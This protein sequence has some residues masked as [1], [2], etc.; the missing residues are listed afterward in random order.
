MNCESKL[1][2]VF[3]KCIPRGSSFLKLFSSIVRPL[4]L[5]IEFLKYLLTCPNNK[6][7]F[8]VTNQILTRPHLFIFKGKEMEMQA[9]EGQPS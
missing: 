9:C 7:K 3:I 4:Y 2:I 8:N 1:L 6:M 5:E